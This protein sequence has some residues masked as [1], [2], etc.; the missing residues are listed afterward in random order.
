MSLLSLYP[1]FSSNPTILHSPL[2]TVAQTRTKTR[3]FVALSTHANAKILKSNRKS[4]YGQQLSLYDDS[5]EDEEE[6]EEE[7]DG[8]N[9]EEDDWLVDDDVSFCFLIVMLFLVYSLVGLL[10][11][12]KIVFVLAC[13]FPTLCKLFW[14]CFLVFESRS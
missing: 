10:F 11:E 6:E 14:R 8:D 3:R 13:K 12:S 2:H 4:R 1:V 5:E 9:V 7:E